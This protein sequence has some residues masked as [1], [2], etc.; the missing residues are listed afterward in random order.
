[1]KKGTS[2]LK[3]HKRVLLGCFLFG[4]LVL[5]GMVASLRKG[6]GSGGDAGSDKPA[7]MEEDVE[8]T[9]SYSRALAA[10][11]QKY[12]PGDEK[13]SFTGGG[14]K[15]P[16]SQKEYTVMI[17]MT[18]S[19]LES[20]FGAATSDLEEI[21]ESGY[22]P[23][24]VNVIVYTGGSRRWNSGVPS[25]C[26]NVMNMGLPEEDRIVANTKKCADMGAP[27]TLASF[28]N[29]CTSN[30]PASHYGL[31]CWDHGG[32][33][34]WGYGSDELFGN[35]SLMLDELERAM[36]KTDFAKNRKLDWVGFDACLMGSVES[37]SLWDEYASYLVASEEVEAGDG[38]NYQFLNKLNSTT[39]PEEITREIVASYGRFYEENKSE[40]SNPD[41][42]LAVVDLSE[43]YRL[44]DALAVLF[45]KMQESLEE[46]GYQSLSR[47][48]KKAKYFGMSAVSGRGDG[49]DLIDIGS[50][51]KQLKE[52]YPVEAE[53]V[54]KALAGVVI[55]QESNVKDT[56]GLSIYLP[57]DNQTLYKDVGRTMSAYSPT[58]YQNYVKTYAE[59]WM[60]KSG[61]DW[62]LPDF[63]DQENEVTLSLTKEQIGEVAGAYYNVLTKTPFEGYSVLLCWVEITPD[64]NGLLHIPKDPDLITAE[65][66]QILCTNPWGFRQVQSEEGKSRYK[67]LNC[68]LTPSQEFQDIDANKD[69]KADVY[70][71]MDENRQITIDQ[72][73]EKEDLLG[74]SGKNDID[75]SH[76]RTIVDGSGLVY[77]P[78]RDQEG[79][80]K[81]FYEW[82]SGGYLFSTTPLEKQFHFVSRKASFFGTDCVGQVFIQD[83]YGDVH[84]SELCSL[85]A[86][87]KDNRAEVKTKKGKMTFLLAEDHAELVR[88]QG[89]D[90]D[91]VIPEK[92]K[93]LPVT[94]IGR[95]V[96]YD[97]AGSSNESVTRI[98]FPDTL[99]EIE[100]MAFLNRRSVQEVTL[101]KGLVEIGYHAFSN[102]HLKKIDLPDSLEILGQSAF[103]DNDFTTVTLPASLKT[104]GAIPFNDCMSLKEIRVE[105]PSSV[106]TDRDGVLFSADG[107]RLIQYPPAKGASYLVPEGTKTIGYGAFGHVDMM[108]I[109]LPEG[110]TT[111]ENCA[112]FGCVN[113]EIPLFPD[114]LAEIGDLAFG[115]IVLKSEVEKKKTQGEIRIPAKVNYIG[116]RCFQALK[117]TGFTVDPKNKKYASKGGFL[118]NKEKET[119]LEAPLGMQ[120]VVTIPDGIIGLEKDAMVLYPS[121]TRFV[122]PDTL[123]RIPQSVFPHSYGDQKEDGTYEEI[124]NI[125]LYASKGSAGETYAKKY[126]IN[127]Q[128]PL[129]EEEQYLGQKEIALQDGGTMVFDLY[130][131]H[132]EMIS[133]QGQA[134]SLS[135]PEEVEDHP[136]TVLGNGKYSITNPTNDLSLIM[137]QT[138]KK[139]DLPAS[140]K[141]IRKN[142]LEGIYLESV[143][144]DKDNPHLKT[145]DGVLISAD[146]KKLIC[147]PKAKISWADEDRSY[148][149]PDGV[150]T[151]ES[152]AFAS[153]EIT[154][155]SFPASLRKVGDN[156]FAYCS[157]LAKVEWNQ[158]LETIGQSAFS[159]T[160]LE[161]ID[162]PGTI[163]QIESEA[164]AFC[165]LKEIRLPEGLKEIGE[166]AFNYNSKVE[167][168]S[169]PESLETI[170]KR[171]FS[172][173]SEEEEKAVIKEMHI[174]SGVKEIKE[175]AFDQLLIQRFT[176]DEKNK[177]YSS[178]EGLI[179]SKNGKTLYMC[180]S[181]GPETLHIPDGVKKIEDGAFAYG[182]TLKHVY[183]P[184]SVVQIAE[185][186]FERKTVDGKWQASLTIH[187]GKDSIAAEFA[188]RKG[189]T[190]KEE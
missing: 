65:T 160:G 121:D 101:N 66:D 77:M 172:I 134:E 167:T 154:N 124:Y 5:V 11:N 116:D 163:R 35:D 180:P 105:G 17:Y 80:L 51:S 81:P 90:Q 120:G 173:S 86:E 110:L 47:Y 7:L 58:E 137:N 135:V 38:W 152:G 153:C 2:F 159:N 177:T 79:R 74:M 82:E 189:I 112:F 1:M 107:T 106:V 171:A 69:L 136:V 44:E 57:G 48:R 133:Y 26:N 21:M 104:V 146:G 39:D 75:V 119:I 150:E 88:Y 27:D 129:S 62:T 50:L 175:K 23:D 64:E 12:T 131:D 176:V 122:L 4:L 91:L 102:C 33:P 76:Y 46:G 31:V 98:T 89:K 144:V 96:L 183:I 94:R 95:S 164:F 158:G 162:L 184:D 3:S 10:R 187:A 125:T 141:E 43:V 93:G 42:T 123:F 63:R 45:G 178:R 99:K 117:P 40:F 130:G 36:Q 29:F 84:P 28:I 138:L 103:S 18:G 52:E 87:E 149:V 14:E 190:L 181:N 139:I 151:I 126:G 148:K 32:G 100:P 113:L 143:D 186:A 92:V 182:G 165:Q 83:I 114:S 140:L 20:R 30:Y 85:T 127:C 41:A 72:V 174:P 147:F 6:A 25:T 15:L 157:S 60:G 13:L 68:F 118:T 34:L 24:R 185:G 53:A 166:G 70:V 16:A 155:V 170:G 55:E 97:D 111:I 145:E 78:S 132:A 67:T 168:I 8:V 109:T 108:K 161:K 61:L 179:L 56:S 156:A 37:A 19:N 188:L 142:A 9:R 128:E 22:D 59:S 71:S 169:L 49:Y 73:S 54:E 115:D